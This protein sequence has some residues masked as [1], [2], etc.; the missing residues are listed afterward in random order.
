MDRNN[1]KKFLRNVALLSLPLACATAFAAKPVDL[2]QQN[3][4]YLQSLLN[5]PAVATAGLNEVSRS[6]DFNQ[7]LHVRV[8]QTYAGYRVWG[9]DGV[10]HIP[11]GAALSGSLQSVISAAKTQ[12]FMNGTFYD[13]LNA[14]LASAPASVFTKEQAEK[15]IAHAVSTYQ[16]TTR[17]V[18][19]ISD[20]KS[21]LIVYIDKSNKAHWAFLTGFYVPA[22]NAHSMPASPVYITD[23]VTLEVYQHWNNI[24]TESNDQ[25]MRE[26][27]GGGFGGNQK[28][29]E[30]IYDGLAGD[31]P[32]LKVKREPKTSLCYWQNSKV[33]VLHHDTHKVMTF[34]CDAKNAEHN[35]VYWE[36]DK[37]AVNGGYSPSDDALFGGEVISDMYSEW[38][39]VPVLVK[40]GKPM[41]LTMVVH[42]DMDNAYWDGKQM[43]FGDGETTFYPLT[44]LGVASHEISHGFTE[45]H[46]GLAYY[47]QSG[48]MNEAFSD[49]AA[50]A[51]EYYAYGKNSWQIGPEIFKNPDEA[52][53]YMDKPSKDCHGNTPG[54][55]CS[56]DEVSQY[57]EGLDVHFS[58]G[59]YNRVFYLIGSAD[60]WNAR[61]AFDIM[62]Q[63]NMNYW[64][65]N[66]T[67]A[68]GACGV[69]RAAYDYKYSIDTVVNA[70]NTVGVDV[71]DC[72]KTGLMKK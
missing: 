52:L 17:S 69:I 44:S 3:A 36:A 31:L 14:D 35:N 30:L 62:V 24:Q 34:P 47:G 39:K 7:T 29:G 20:Q 21:E 23:A 6:V 2:G 25:E 28:M 16:K 38:Y 15:A 66:T 4:T 72:F 68:S 19:A 10:V 41:M 12:G 40:D 71:K 33:T 42:A 53:R 46:S 63:A 26:V 65:P 18:G 5:R 45:Q 43:T 9:G 70:F 8:K 67:F 49:M 48:G 27:S 64:T 11:H 1:K 57:S 13:Q 56:I 37:D 54:S 51:A 59:I 22:A 61:K 58:S 32:S 50:Q 60:G 55:W